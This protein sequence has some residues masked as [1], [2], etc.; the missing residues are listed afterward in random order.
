MTYNP[1]DER[2]MDAYDAYL[3]EAGANFGKLLKFVKGGWYI[4]D[5]EV[6]IGTEY[7][8]ILYEERRGYVKFENGKPTDSVLGLVREGFKMPTRASLGDNDPH[9]W[10]KNKKGEPQDIWAPQTYLPIL[11][12]ATGEMLCFVTGSQGG[13]Q[14]LR[15]LMRDYKPRSRTSDVPIISLQTDSYV[16]GDYGRVQVPVLKIV[17][18]H[19][20]G[21]VP[22]P[23]VKVSMLP[24]Q[25]SAPQIVHHEVEPEPEGTEPE[26]AEPARQDSITSGP[27]PQPS[28]AELDKLASN[29]K[30]SAKA[31]QSAKAKKAADPDMD[32][33]I[34][35]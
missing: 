3:N 34:P 26:D 21:Y 8:A 2:E 6:E 17:G 35:F 32:D 18:W 31:R 19:D 29:A 33:S 30:Q 9:Y 5:D 20:L 23:P 22:P 16:H 28:Q 15:N 27:Q 7:A 14:T 11:D 12:I 1:E 13:E 25:T 24:R 4:G 10:P